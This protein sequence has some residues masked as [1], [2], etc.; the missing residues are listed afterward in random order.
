MLWRSTTAEP[1][2]NFTFSN[3]IKMYHEHHQAG[4]ETMKIRISKSPVPLK[5]VNKKFHT[6][7]S[8][9]WVIITNMYFYIGQKILQSDRQK[10]S[11]DK[12]LMSCLICT[13][14]WRLQWKFNDKWLT[15]FLL[16]LC[17]QCQTWFITTSQ[18]RKTHHIWD[19]IFEN[20]CWSLQK[21]RHLKGQHQKHDR[22]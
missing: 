3:M 2:S 22:C 11:K 12:Q 17:Y 20:G 21:R 16:I 9:H 14:I 7:T 4:I 1:F 6:H 15:I 19:E 5:T 13:N 10:I 8:T 18:Q